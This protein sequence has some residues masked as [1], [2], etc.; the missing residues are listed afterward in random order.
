MDMA[1]VDW[2]QQSLPG[3]VQLPSPGQAWDVFSKSADQSVVSRGSFQYGAEKNYRLRKQGL[4]NGSYAVDAIF[5]FDL[6][7]QRNFIILT[8]HATRM[9]T[10]RSWPPKLE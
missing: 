6:R 2:A 3:D 1:E 10:T 9:S 8:C 7:R 4:A 5:G